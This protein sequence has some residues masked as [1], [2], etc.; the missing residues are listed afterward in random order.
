MTA[1]ASQPT[2]AVTYL[3]STTREPAAGLAAQD[4]VW[5]WRYPRK[6]CCITGVRSGW[7]PS[8]APAA[9]SI[10]RCPCGRWAVISTRA[11]WQRT[12]RR[13]MPKTVLV[14]DDEPYI[15]E[16]V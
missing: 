8:S 11:H 6:S 4:Q 5:D 3:K 7:T 14:C 13:E 10:S 12:R 16:V 1:R 9:V 15:L 2:S